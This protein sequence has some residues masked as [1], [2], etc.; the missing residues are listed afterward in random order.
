MTAGWVF[1]GMII[2]SVVTSNGWVAA[3]MMAITI[4][5]IMKTG[6]ASSPKHR[7]LSEENKRKRK[8]IAVYLEIIFI[9]IILFGKNSVVRKGVFAGTMTTNLQVIIRRLREWIM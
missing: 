1:G 6:I 2:G 9:M 4:I 7:A 8:Q 5:T 3:A